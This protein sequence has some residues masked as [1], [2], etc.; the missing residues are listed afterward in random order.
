MFTP[1][2]ISQKCA[3]KTTSIRI[4]GAHLENADLG[5]Q[6]QSCHVRTPVDGIWKLTC[7]TS[8]PDDSCRYSILRITH[9]TYI[10]G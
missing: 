7:F 9:I 6:A 10:Q 2:G 5:V 3:Q 1:V 8:F 4:N